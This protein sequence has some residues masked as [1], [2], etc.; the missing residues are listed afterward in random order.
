M[1]S[2]ARTGGGRRRGKPRGGGLFPWVGG[3][4]G[5]RIP[6]LMYHSVAD[7]DE[8]AL[9]PYYWIATA[10]AQFLQQMT[11]LHERGYRTASLASAVGLLQDGRGTVERTVVI[12]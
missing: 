5:D 2:R 3:R 10:P 11:W 6:I 9:Q 7:E 8:S 4:H 1:Q 12:D